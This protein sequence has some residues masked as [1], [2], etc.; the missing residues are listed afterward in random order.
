MADDHPVVREGLKKLLTRAGFC[1]VAEGSNGEEVLEKAKELHPELVLWDL[2]MPAGGLEGL[3]RLRET[4][5]QLKVLVLTAL[6]AP[7]LGGEALRAGAHGCVAK[8]ATPEEIISAIT[9]VLRG[10]LFLPQ[11]ANLSSREREVL[12]LL[13][14]GLR[15]NQIAQELGISP[16]TVESHLEN[17]KEK[18]GFHTTTELRALALRWQTPTDPPSSQI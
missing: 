8:T 11:E 16:K 18:L 7:G 12:S 15:L 5:P 13:A 2:V 9:T 1:V 3:R 6:D 14:R 4:L 10:E 17:L